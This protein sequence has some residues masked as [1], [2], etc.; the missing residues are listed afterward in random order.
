M[1]AHAPPRLPL[2]ESRAEV[3]P[4]ADAEG[5]PLALA[6]GSSSAEESEANVRNQVRSAFDETKRE[7]DLNG[8]LS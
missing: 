7:P 1:N 6:H 5:A 2:P 4:E 3:L 8:S